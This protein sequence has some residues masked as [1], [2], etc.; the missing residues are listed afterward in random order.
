MKIAVL[1]SGAVSKRLLEH[2]E[3]SGFDDEITVYSDH[4]DLVCS[5][6]KEY[7]TKKYKELGIRYFDV[8]FGCLSKDKTEELFPFMRTKLLIDNSELFRLNATIPLVVGNVN[9]HLISKDTTIVANPNCV[10][11]MLAHLLLPLSQSFEIK[12][13][14]CTTLQSVSG[15]GVGG[16]NRL[17]EEESDNEFLEGEVLPRFTFNGEAKTMYGNIVPLV[18]AIENNLSTH[19]ENKISEE[20]KKLIAPNFEISTTCLRVPV[21]HGHT[22]V[23]HVTLNEPYD[24]TRLLRF[25]DLKTRLHYQE[26]ITLKDAIADRIRVSITRIKP[27]PLCPYAFFAT[28]FSDN[29]SLGAAYNSFLVYQ[30]YRRLN[31]VL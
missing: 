4:T 11:L 25:I 9:S 10:V 28:L 6:N 21:K 8:V 17:A 15:L 2:L 30:T 23:V 24:Q 20:F 18:G 26:F 3:E 27:D 5:K 1:G 29:L 12:K 31:N 7:H 16:L 13:V 19:E 22:A 14:I